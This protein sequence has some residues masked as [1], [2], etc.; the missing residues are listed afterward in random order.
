MKPVSVLDTIYVVGRWDEDES[1]PWH[2]QGA[3]TCK[4]SAELQARPGYFIIP[5]P[6]NQMLPHERIE[7]NGS[8]YPDVVPEDR[9]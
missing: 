7:D 5:V 4:E 3:F 1:L 8:W 2:V 6:V 9:G